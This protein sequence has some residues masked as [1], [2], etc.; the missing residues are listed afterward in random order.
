MREGPNTRGDARS[1]SALFRIAAVLS[2]RLGI[3]ASRL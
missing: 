1:P 3:D 2:T